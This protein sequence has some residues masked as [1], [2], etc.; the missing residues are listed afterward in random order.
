[1]FSGEQRNEAGT[2]HGWCSK[3]GGDERQNST[4]KDLIF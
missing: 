3:E 4:G 1:M 2:T